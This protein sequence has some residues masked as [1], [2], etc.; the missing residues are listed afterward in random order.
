MID[1]L[2]KH[3][4]LFKKAECYLI[5]PNDNNRSRLKYNIGSIESQAS[6]IDVKTIDAEF[7]DGVIKALAQSGGM[8]GFGFFF[9]DPFGLKA[10]DYTSVQEIASTPKFDCLITLMTKELIRWQDSEGHEE[11]F[12]TLYGTANWKD[13]LQSYQ[14]R[15]LETAEAEYYCN[16]LEQDGVGYTLA[17]M[18]TRGDSIELMYDLV[19][20]TNAK[21][22]LEAMKESAT[23]CGSDYTL[24]YAPQRAD[25]GGFEQAT[26][27]G[28][29][30][31][32]EEKRA[33]AYLVSRFAGQVLTFD[34]VVTKVFEDPSRRYADSLR[35]DYRQYLKELDNDGDVDIP[36]RDR[37]DA[38]LGKHYEIRF[39]EMEE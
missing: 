22:G 11:T 25:I 3:Q 23:R 32:T 16:R 5:E 21:E 30:I 26:L 34:E 39:P 36:E 19:F 28:G 1:I 6:N 2:S 24:A 35:Q 37:D 18:T 4:H 20:T 33:K 38:P 13:E 29:Q 14:P 12:K 7:S 10:L 8:K 15:H 31:M 27:T 17:Y 9:M